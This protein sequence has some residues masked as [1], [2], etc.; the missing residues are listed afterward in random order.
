M[1]TV[2]CIKTASLEHYALYILV[3]CCIVQNG[4]LSGSETITWSARDSDVHLVYVKNYDYNSPPGFPGSG[5]AINFYGAG[6]GEHKI[7]QAP[8]SAVND[9]RYVVHTL[10]GIQTW[11]ICVQ[12]VPTVPYLYFY[13]NIIG[14]K[15]YIYIFGLIFRYWVVACFDGSVGFS[16]ITEINT[17]SNSEPGPEV[18]G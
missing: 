14:I 8:T 18:C 15:I 4:G 17:T 13:I 1:Q 10:Y 6:G 12:A 9:Q 5:A 2:T 11:G 7:I 3:Y 16:S